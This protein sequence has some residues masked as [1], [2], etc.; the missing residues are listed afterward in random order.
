MCI[1]RKKV[2]SIHQN[3]NMVNGVQKLERIVFAFLFPQFLLF[4]T[5]TKTF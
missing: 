5:K 1:Q 2:L 3:F 4:K